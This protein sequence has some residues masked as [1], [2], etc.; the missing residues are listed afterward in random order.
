MEYKSDKDLSSFLYRSPYTI[1]SWMKV[2]NFP[3]P[4]ILKFKFKNLQDGYKNG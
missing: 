4:E 1:V 3:N 2:Q